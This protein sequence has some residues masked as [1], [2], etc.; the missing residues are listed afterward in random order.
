MNANKLFLCL[1]VI[2][3]L[4]TCSG[5]L[6]D[7][8]RIDEGETEYAGVS[9]KSA[10]EVG[11]KKTYQD[12][13]DAI[14]TFESSIDPV[15]AKEYADKYLDSNAVRYQEVAKPG[16]VIRDDNGVPLMETTSYKDYF[17]KL[18]IDHLYVPGSTD[19][20]MFRR[21]QYSVT[22]FLGFIGYQFSEADLWAL[23]YYENY[24]AYGNQKYYSDVPVSHWA[25]GVRSFVEKAGPL[26]IRI[27][28][29]NTWTGSFTGK[30]GIHT[31]DDFKDPEKQDFIAKDHF[32]FKHDRIAEVLA[33]VRKKIDN[34]L[35]TT[36]YW[37][38][39]HPPVSPPPGGRSNTVTVT[40]SGMLAAAHLR[41]ADGV[42]DLV[43]LHKNDHDEI[44]TYALQYMQDYAGYN[45]P[46][47]H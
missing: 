32:T 12:F 25:H 44:G 23:G 33:D 40:M 47:D 35:G 5:M 45:T 36:L 8:L 17:L 1:C 10:T 11:E 15:M 37:N 14:R 38:Q 30:H 42:K 26:Q 39:M 18:G 2:I 6:L 21:M 4:S 19:L 31:M 43:Y 16:R 13:L 28:D 20:E 27:T 9:V 3:L 22:N 41:G 24:D 29:V 7:S 34:Y 46:F